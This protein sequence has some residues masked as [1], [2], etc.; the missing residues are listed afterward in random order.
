[1]NEVHASPGGLLNDK[2]AMWDGLGKAA[3]KIAF[4]KI[5]CFNRNTSDYFRQ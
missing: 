1:M 5:L 3:P 4:H 2:G